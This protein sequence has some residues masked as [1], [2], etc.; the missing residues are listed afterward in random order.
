M[1]SSPASAPARAAR[2]FTLIEI[3]VV[4]ALIGIVLALVANRMAD[5][6]VKGKVAATKISLDTLAGD[7]QTYALDVG[8]PPD[9][10]DDLMKK[11]GNATN[12]N[13]PYARDKDLKDPWG[14]PFVYH[15]P[16]THGND[17]DL[18]SMGPDGKEGG[19]G[20]RAADI[21]NWDK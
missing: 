19:E 17:F 10:L 8:N 18:Y 7:I 16:G 20:L 21:V 12:W 15:S 4:M 14:H 9:K 6:S 5:A 11:P 3:L 13:G 1:R 2:G